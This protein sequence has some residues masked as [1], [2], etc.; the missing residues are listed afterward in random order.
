MLGLLEGVPLFYLSIGTTLM[1]AA[2]AT[3]MLRFDEW[4]FRQ[5]VKDKL[6]FSDVR[7][8]KKLNAAGAVESIVL[9]FILRSSAV[10]PIEF[11]VQELQTRLGETFPPKKL[12][13]KA[14]LIIPAGGSGWFDDYPINVTN[15]SKGQSLEGSMNF[16][17]MYGRPDQ[18][19]HTLS[20]NIQ[21]FIGFDEKG[22]A[23]LGHWNEA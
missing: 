20:K 7:V 10:F 16:T 4:R 5:R 17:V 12:Y 22:D 15:V 21:V 14:R 8:A 9:G 18:L 23:R 6:N 11:D 13:K 3:G 19:K 2:T 1:F